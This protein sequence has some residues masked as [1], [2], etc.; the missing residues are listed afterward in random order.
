MDYILPADP[1]FDDISKLVWKHLE[2][3]DWHDNPSR[4]IAV[5]IVLEAAELLEKYQ[6]QDKPVGDRDAVA[7]ELADIFIYS[8]QL[9][10]QLDID[11]PEAIRAKLET[12]AQKYPAE[13]FKGIPWEKSREKWV[14]DK[15]NHPKEGL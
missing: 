2:E 7:S 12:S 5:S 9:A 4:S 14:E 11:L 15:L 10:R 3:R 13:H 1:T 6:W 8:L